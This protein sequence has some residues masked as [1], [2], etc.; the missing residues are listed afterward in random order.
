MKS[1]EDQTL[2]ALEMSYHHR[3]RAQYVIDI[4]LTS[5]LQSRANL[6]H[7]HSWTLEVVYRDNV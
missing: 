7:H 2:C 3:A 5:F 1:T 4:K 6:Y